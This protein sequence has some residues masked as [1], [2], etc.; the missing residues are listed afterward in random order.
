MHMLDVGG[1]FED[2]S[3]ETLAY[4]LREAIAREFSSSVTVIAEPGR[5]YASG[6]YTMV[7]RV[8]ARRTQLGATRASRPDMLYLNDGV[9]GCFSMVWCEGGIVIPT[10]IEPRGKTTALAPRERGHHRY[11]IWGPTCDSIDR[12]SE[13]VVMDQEVKVGDWLKFRDMGGE[14]FLLTE[15]PNPGAN[16]ALNSIY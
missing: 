9:Y 8:I 3:F 2:A 5:F 16:N 15:W 10:L 7:C 4:P 12:I 14:C 6:F 11:S 13:E 1:G